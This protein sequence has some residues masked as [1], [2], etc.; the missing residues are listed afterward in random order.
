MWTQIS[1]QQEEQF[2]AAAVRQFGLC[3]IEEIAAAAAALPF[4]QQK[5]RAKTF[6]SE[7][8]T[9]KEIREAKEQQNFAHVAF[10]FCF[11]LLELRL[12]FRESNRHLGLANGHIF[13]I[14]KIQAV[15]F[16]SL[17]YMMREGR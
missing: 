12:P 11:V 14:N 6:L 3:W 7:L 9:K 13:F 10:L 4:L 1:L 8:N 5:V 15:A 2:G 16:T 17:S